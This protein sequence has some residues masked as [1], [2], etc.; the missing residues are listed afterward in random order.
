MKLGIWGLETL[1]GKK[2]ILYNLEAVILNFGNPEGG[3][4]VHC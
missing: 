2:N 4:G 1:R 3:K